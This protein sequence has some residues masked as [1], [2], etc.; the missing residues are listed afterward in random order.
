MELIV[1]NLEKSFKLK[2]VS[3]E[4][5]EEDE[6][7]F[8][9]VVSDEITSQ[10]ETRILTPDKCYPRQKDMLAVHW[11]PEHVPLPLIKKRIEIVFPDLESSL[12]I[13]TQ[14]NCLME[15]GDFAG[16]EIDCYSRG[17]NQKVQLLL[18]FEKKRIENA[19]V[20][21]GMLSH[22]FR[23]RSSQ[24][25][26]FMD[27]LTRPDEAILGLAASETGAGNDLIRFVCTT[28]KKIRSL[29]DKH[30][31]RIPPQSIKNKV[32]KGYFDGLRTQYPDAWIDR[33]QIF[34]REVKKGV[35]EAFPL[36]YFYR[37]SE[38]IEEV[39]SLK[40]C[41]VI[42]HPEQFWPILLAGYD[43]DGY[44]VWNPQSRRYTEFLI[45]VVG[46]KNKAL[47]PSKRKILIF[48]GDD[49]HMSAK[50]AIPSKQDAIKAKREIGVQPAWEDL[51]IKK[52]LILAHMDRNRVIREY[53]ARL[54]D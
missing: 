52:K 53:T 24:L 22:T 37:T 18:H 47:A 2:E 42:P 41:I 33:V 19:Q 27:A 50:L 13:P 40:G 49:T 10:E 17:F 1:N 23:Y 43:V 35:K 28:T 5:T 4:P 38:V 46:N 54:T 8:L 6:K 11:H 3:P 29:L 21:K 36:R 39:R 31:D 26:A 9:S 30:Y 32:L 7:L 14:H 20:L 16:T 48:M 45:D 12:I 15:Y 34:L 51:S 44:E 25:F